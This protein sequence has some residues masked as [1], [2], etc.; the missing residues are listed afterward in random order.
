MRTQKSV[1]VP[2]KLS[3]EVRRGI[4]IG[5]NLAADFKKHWHPAECDGVDALKTEIRKL[6]AHV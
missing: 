3:R 2:V 1:K 5:L 4:K 6:A